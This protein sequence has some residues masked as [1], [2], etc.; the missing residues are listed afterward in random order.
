[1]SPALENVTNDFLFPVCQLNPVAVADYPAYSE[2]LAPELILPKHLDQDEINDLIEERYRPRR[3]TKIGGYPSFIQDAWYPTCKEC[4]QNVEFIFQLA[5]GESID[6]V[7][8]N[9][10][11]HWSD[12]GLTIGDLGNIYAYVC[13]RCR[14]NDILTYWDCY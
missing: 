12:H 2:E 8:E 1:M 13:K 11:P 14:P 3:G 9:E 5:T 4:K 10:Y 7:T 6:T